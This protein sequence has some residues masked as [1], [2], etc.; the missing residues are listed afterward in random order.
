MIKPPLVVVE[1]PR[2]ESVLQLAPGRH[3]Y[4]TAEWKRYAHWLTDRLGVPRDF[5]TRFRQREARIGAQVP[6][7][8]AGN[9][10]LRPRRQWRGVLLKRCD[11]NY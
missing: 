11:V 2:F 8:I 10:F 4:Y 7:P 6:S 3:D 5:S 1:R 9:L